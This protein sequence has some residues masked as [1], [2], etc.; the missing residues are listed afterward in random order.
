MNEQPPFTARGRAQ[1]ADFSDQPEDTQSHHH[2]KIRR[3]PVLR[4]GLPTLLRI[5]GVQDTDTAL[6]HELWKVVS[7]QRVWVSGFSQAP[8]V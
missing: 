8:R 1:L 4:N 5:A 7:V 3:Q 6:K 2:A